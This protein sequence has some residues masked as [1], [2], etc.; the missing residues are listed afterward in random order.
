MWPGGFL[1]PLQRIGIV[2]PPLV[3]HAIVQWHKRVVAQLTLEIPDEIEA[4]HRR[5]AEQAGVS[6]SKYV[7][8]KLAPLQTTWWPHGYLE[9]I[10][11]CLSEDFEE[12]VDLPLDPN[13][14]N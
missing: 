5:E 14:R 6:L 7:V 4:R 3:Y 2:H 12:P 11:G 1:I 9:S 8:D 10:R 13:G